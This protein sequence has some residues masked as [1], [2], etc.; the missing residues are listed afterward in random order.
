MRLQLSQWLRV[1]DQ[2][3]AQ[4]PNK[5]HRKRVPS[6]WPLALVFCALVALMPVAATGALAQDLSQ[7][8]TIGGRTRQWLVHLPSG[9]HAGRRVPLVVAFHGHGS[10]AANMVRLTKLDA[11][12]DKLDFIVVY[13]QGVDQ[14]WAAGVDSPADEAGVDDVAFAGAMLNRLEREYSINSAR[15]VF[16]GFSNGAHLVQRIGCRMAARL[17][18]IVPVSGTLALPLQSAC[19]PSR[20]LTVVAFHGTAD[21]I[22]PY[23]GGNIHIHGG[24]AVLPVTVAMADWAKWDGCAAKPQTNER[25]AV[26]EIR[27]TRVDWTACH[28]GV[29]VT[30]YRIEGGGHTW[31][32]GPQYLPR[33][34]IG[35]ATHVVAA[36]DVIGAIAT[37][38]WY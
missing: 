5:L 14:S 21:P 2:G 37:G 12:A 13:A 30:L 9:Y 6:L 3:Q 26:G 4:C 31:P 1:R 20:P 23:A 19:H 8:A 22:D 16:T 28:D 10:S 15:V 32:G 7:S 38:R 25:T 29:H 35:N 34:L 11:V 24:G 18:A 17:H 36:S 33:F 27:L